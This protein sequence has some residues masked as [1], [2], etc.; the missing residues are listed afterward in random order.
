M[1]FNINKKSKK[2]MKQLDEDLEEEHK[3]YNRE[4]K[5]D[6]VDPRQKQMSEQDHINMYDSGYTAP[7]I[8]TVKVKCK[9]CSSETDCS[10]TSKMALLS[11]CNFCYKKN[12]KQ[13]TG[14]VI[15][16]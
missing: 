8:K 3:I 14:G 7:G 6:G 13:D 16:I 1:V 5:P 2:A 15:E 4:Q 12:K 11:I 9:L 10:E